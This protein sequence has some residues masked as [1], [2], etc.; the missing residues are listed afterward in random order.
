MAAKTEFFKVIPT[1]NALNLLF[2]HLTPFSEIIP[3]PT[4]E[5]LGRILAISPT[6]PVDLPDFRRSTMDGFAVIASDTF[7]ASE[8]LPAYLDVQ[9]HVLMGEQPDFTLQAGTAAEIHTGAMLPDGADAIVMIERTQRISD[10]EIEVLAP[11]A[12]G[13]NVVQIG[14]DIMHG[15][16]V[17]PAGHY[18]R[19]QDIGGLLALGITT[20]EVLKRPRV[21]VL[22]CGDELVEPG[23]DATIGQIRDI[24]SYMLV[25]LLQELGADAFRLGVARDT[26]DAL[27]SLARSGLDDA[28]MLVMSAGSSVSVRDLT[29]A[30]IEKLGSPGIVQ[31]GLAVK[32]GKPTIIAACDGKPVIGLPGN[33]ASAM[34][35]ARQTLPPILRYLTGQPTPRRS[36]I[37][38]TLSA[39]IASTTGREDTIAIRLIDSDEGVIAEPVFGKSNLIYTLINADGYLHVPLNSNGLKAGTIVDVTLF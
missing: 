27:Y 5:A 38:A 3:L 10:T 4:W 31:H 11:V 17:L 32:P 29:N 13:E 39:N 19:S 8:S 14:E 18:L 26:M 25:A 36:S 2:D 28:D 16:A 30:V 23:E 12:P 24:N 1:S 37:K 34:A 20:V 21:A 33:P 22:S 7:G 35:V 6:A 15:N 9:H